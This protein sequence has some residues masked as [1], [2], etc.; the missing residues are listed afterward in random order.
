MRQKHSG[1]QGEPESTLSN[2]GLRQTPSLA[3]ARNLKCLLAPYSTS[4]EESKHY[5]LLWAHSTRVYRH[6]QM[7]ADKVLNG[8]CEPTRKS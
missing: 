2:H 7:V 5:A 4:R 3:A 1:V 8:E 6:V